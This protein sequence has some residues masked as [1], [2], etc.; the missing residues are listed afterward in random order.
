MD[1]NITMTKNL[2]YIIFI[3]FLLIAFFSCASEPQPIPQK[4]K[5]ITQKQENTTPPAEKKEEKPSQ[6][7]NNQ[8]VSDAVYNKTFADVQDFIA[9]L[10]KI[11]GDS[12]FEEWKKYLTQEYINYYSNPSN[13]REISKNDTLKK[14]NIVL[15]SLKDYF[16]YVVAPSRSDVTL[17][18]I[19]FFDD[20]NVKAYTIIDGEPAI[21]YN[22]VKI[23][24]NW[25]IEK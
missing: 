15:R 6:P 3:S 12:N 1:N 16:T 2:F 24:N 17:D 10:N 22:L 20:N 8:G 4:Q 13:L 21:L 25:K 19:S 11:I 14:Y 7:A 5:P 18:S 23:N 9:K